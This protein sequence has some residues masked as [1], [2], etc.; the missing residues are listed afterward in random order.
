MGTNAALKFRSSSK[1]LGADQEFEQFSSW[2][3]HAW[4]I[5]RHSFLAGME[6]DVSSD[7]AIPVQ[8]LY[9]AGG[10]PR[11]SGY[12]YNELLGENFGMVFGGYRY[13]LLEGSI[14][15]GYLGGTIEYG[16][17][18]QDYSDLFSDGILNGSVYLGIDSIIG[19]MYLGMGFAEGGRR[20]PFFSIGSIF[21]RD[22]LTR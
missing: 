8:S 21:S 19:P 18:Y 12:E 6:A 1:A 10:F 5:G 7:D 16:N 22:S 4:T 2:I 20:V 14:F 9:R 3:A 13:K 17:V 15:P 11:M